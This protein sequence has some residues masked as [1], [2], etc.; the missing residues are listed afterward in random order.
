MHQLTTVWGEQPDRDNV[1]PE[2][3]R[4]QLV[5][6]SY[7]NLNGT[8]DMTITHSPEMPKEF[9]GT[10]L[11]PF[12]PESKLSGVGHVLLPDEY[13]WY[14]RTFNFVG[15]AQHESRHLILHFG[16]VDQEAEVFVNGSSVC[17]HVGGYQPFHTD[18]TE[19]VTEG[20][21][22]I[23]VKVRD[24]TDTTYLARG[25]Q[26][27][28]PG[29]MFYTP[30]SGIWQ[31]VWME[32]V[33]ANYVEW[34]KITPDYDREVVVFEPFL[35]EE[36][37]QT[38]I[39]IFEGEK[40][41]GTFTFKE[42]TR[43]SVPLPKFKAWSPEDPFLYNYE[44]VAGEDRVT[45][46]FAMRKFSVGQDDRGIPRLMLNNRPYF[47]NGLLDQGYWPDG[48]YTAPTDEALAYDVIKCK[49]LG[50]NM[51]RKH[52][53][54]EPLRWYY[55]CDRIG[56][57]VWQD[58]V[59]SGDRLDSYYVTVRPTVLP[60]TQENT[61][62][63][64]NRRLRR[65]TR[66]SVNCY[67]TE[68]D[69]TIK[70]LYSC[71]CIAVWTLFNE[72]W[73][74]YRAL[75]AAEIAH[76]LDPTRLIDHASGWFDMGGGDMKSLHIYFTS[77]KFKPDKRPVV[78][79]EFG[80]Y[81]LPTPGH[82][83]CDKVYGYRKYKYEADFTSAYEKLYRDKIIAQMDRGL[84][85]SVYTQVSDIEEEINGLLTYDRKHLKIDSDVVH[86]INIDLSYDN[87]SRH[88]IKI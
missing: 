49:E 71:P 22:T 81:S 3:P 11:V 72:G 52:A 83:A 20:V 77:F 48:I 26:K 36:E 54:V 8:W 34:V 35:T 58:I 29:G 84:C 87:G 65:Q 40:T 53:K 18:I 33:P 24:L 28:K 12:C 39:T 31:T 30:V 19:Y 14:R 57:I 76:R 15:L 9:D 23:I 60:A 61:N 66:A 56:M 69:S 45:G 5:R 27:L 46:Y 10:I 44:L 2:Y 73:G 47:H 74:Q 70:N 55:H 37:V 42:N 41:V 17:S 64:D 63:V 79:S 88:S 78:I 32:E 21:N 4:P 86:R 68:L 50:F 51:L 25:K 6:D 16:A 43:I 80:G 59:N 67:L 85:A 62:D 13:L 82:M 1:L 38:V 75:E 7:I